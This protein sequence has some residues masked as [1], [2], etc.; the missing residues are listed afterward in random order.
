M[1]GKTVTAEAATAPSSIPTTGGSAAPTGARPATAAA[2][3]PSPAVFLLCETCYWCATFLGKGKAVFDGC[4]SCSGTV[5]SSF[6]IMPDEAFAFSYDSK[7]GVELDFEP[8]RKKKQ[9][10]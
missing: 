8:R 1:E 9:Q 4:P 2:A 5:L 3:A 10:Q 7:H 6:P